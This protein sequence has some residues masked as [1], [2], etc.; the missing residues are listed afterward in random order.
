MGVNFAG[1]AYVYTDGDI[2]FD[3]VLEL[4]DVTMELDTW[5][6]KYIR[7]FELF[8]R[9]ARVD[10]GQGYQEAKWKGLLSGN[11][12]ATSRQGLSDSFARFAVNLYGSPPLAGQDFAAYR[13]T[14]STDT[15]V[16]MGL[17]VR[18]PTGDYQDE[19]LLNL[20]GNRFVFRP[21]LG[22]S[23]TRNKWTSELTAE[24]AIYTDNDKFFDGNELEQDPLYLLHAHL[25]YTFRPGLWVGASLG[26]DYGGEKTVNGVKKDDKKEHLGWGVSAAYPINPVLGVKLAYLNIRSK[27]A[28]GVD[29]DSLVAS[30]TYMW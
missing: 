20:G 5:A 12:A 24:V 3:P 30:L 1:V 28:T 25:M 17:A 15:I 14:R 6:A 23:H 16:G 9:S 7:T 10:I 19:K 13:A 4:E 2:A 22:V 27:S 21:Q 18:L 29:L 8:N 26:Y 11:P